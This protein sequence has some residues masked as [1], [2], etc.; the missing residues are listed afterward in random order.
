MLLCGHH[1]PVLLTVSYINTCIT[2]SFTDIRAVT[3]ERR[4]NIYLFWAVIMVTAPDSPT[5][6]PEG[7]SFA[8][9]L[10]FN[11]HRHIYTISCVCHRINEIELVLPISIHTRQYKITNSYV[12]LFINFGN[13]F[14]V[15]QVTRNQC[16]SKV[17]TTNVLCSQA[18][19]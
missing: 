14:F 17:S 6:T 12:R 11:M 18:S 4:N 1:L 15:S 13:Q 5:C 16:N 3:A 2:C 7:E 9:V 10:F 8:F 19:E